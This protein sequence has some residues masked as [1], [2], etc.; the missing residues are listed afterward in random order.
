MKLIAKVTV[1]V[2]VKGVR[3]RFAPGEEVIGLSRVDVA[4]LKTV[5]AIE[6]QDETDAAAKK[7]ELAEK[8]AG[9][10]FADARKAIQASN[11]AIE[12]PAA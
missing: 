8:K 10:E 7:D 4:D 6:D 12:A 2:F 9:K 5:G 3:T 11:A 1:D